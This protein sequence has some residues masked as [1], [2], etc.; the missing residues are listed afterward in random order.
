MTVTLEEFTKDFTPEERAQVAARTATLIEE[1]LTLRDL[2][3]AQRL[4]QERMAELMG[5][6]QE[7]VSRLE[8]R[9]D[10]LLSTLSSYVAAMGGKL[11]LVA[12]FPGREPIAIG[13]ADIAGKAPLERRQRGRGAKKRAGAEA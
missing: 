10:L 13:L 12:E 2:R 7:N 5:V 1:E 11:R 6:E 9:A 8:R 3:Q 4:T